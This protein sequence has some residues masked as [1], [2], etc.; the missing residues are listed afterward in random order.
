MISIIH[1][2]IRLFFRD[3]PSVFLSLIF[4]VIMIYLLGTILEDVEHA[5]DVISDVNVGWY[6]DTDDFAYKGAIN[7]FIDTVKDEELVK[8]TSIQSLDN[9]LERLKSN[10]L[11]AVVSITG[12]PAEVKIYNGTDQIANR[13]V[14]SIVSGFLVNYNAILSVAQTDP[15]LMTSVA[16]T[17]NS[18]VTDK[19]FGKTRSMIDYYSVTMIV[20][21]MLMVCTLSGADCF[22][23]EKSDK[24][25]DRLTLAPIKP[26]KIFLAGVTGQLP[27]ALIQTIVIMCV[28]VFVFGAR[29]AQ[30]FWQNILLFVCIIIISFSFNT[31]GVILGLICKKRPTPVLLTIT[32][33]MLFLS[34]CFVMEFTFKGISDFLPPYQIQTAIFELT[35]FGRPF[36]LI[37]VTAICIIAIAIMIVTGSV[38]INKKQFKS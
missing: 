4:P 28:S 19:D 8:C 32:W 13:T 11:S 7:E 16:D 21:V 6:V 5:E 24:T 35:D 17:S 14:N 27:Q 9:S 31:F 12:N 30:T 3:K 1:N 23:S 36:P 26:Y 33:I 38:I 2:K 18:K 29:Y 22:I 25:L 34:G 15:Q 37:R 20:M 10:D